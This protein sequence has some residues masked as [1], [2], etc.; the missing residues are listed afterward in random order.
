MK[1]NC[2]KTLNGQTD[3]VEYLRNWH[4]CF[5]WWP[6]IVGD[7]DCRWLETVEKRHPKAWLGASGTI[8]KENV[9][10]RELQP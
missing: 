8:W 5:A 3:Y 10:Y 1:F 4:L 6:V 7:Y 2:N 9:E